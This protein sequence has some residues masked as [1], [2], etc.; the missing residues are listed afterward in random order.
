[1]IDIMM[2][3]M[4]KS[5]LFHFS[6]W[7]LYLLVMHLL[8]SAVMDGRA[9]A[10]NAQMG[11]GLVRIRLGAWYCA[12][13]HMACVDASHGGILRRLLGLFVLIPRDAPWDMDFT[14][15]AQHFYLFDSMLRRMDF[16]RDGLETFFCV[17]FRKE[18]RGR[19]NGFRGSKGPKN[20]LR[21]S[22]RWKV[23]A[24]LNELWMDELNIFTPPHLLP[25]ETLQTSNETHHS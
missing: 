7:T 18:Y 25:S 24:Y 21:G 4:G 12:S 22:T 2:M 5:S 3:A 16:A 6:G 9:L 14:L 19:G 20:C 10:E 1:M 23:C 17:D 15:L 11:Y 13:A 8:A